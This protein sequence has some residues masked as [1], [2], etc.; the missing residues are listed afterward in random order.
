MTGLTLPGM[1]DEPGWRAGSLISAKPVRG[2]DDISSRSS[3]IL[4]RSTASPR[5]AAETA[6]IGAIDCVA[7][8]SCSAVRSSKPVCSARFLTTSSMYS[9]SAFKP[10]P[11]AVAP[12]FCSSSPSAASA[13]RARARANGQRVRREL[14]AQADGHGV[15]HVRAA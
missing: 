2:P 5:S 8:T 9:G 13:I 10:V 14:L 1:I 15:L 12:M 11:T 3:A 6:S 4:A 7:W